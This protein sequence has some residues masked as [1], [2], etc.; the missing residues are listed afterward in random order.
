MK[1]INIPINERD[2][3]KVYVEFL[4]PI[5]NLTKKESDILGEFLYWY[6]KYEYLDDEIRD[7]ILFDYDTKKK[8]LIE[9]DINH[10][11]L[12]NNITSLRKKGWII[13]TKLSE[14]FIS[15][16]DY[17]NKMLVVKFTMMPN[18]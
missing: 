10:Q 17:D 16:V 3:C 13:G 14:K 2:F 15:L 1:A 11:T 5:L 8:I 4:N 6:K 12:L 18:E 7:K 9:L